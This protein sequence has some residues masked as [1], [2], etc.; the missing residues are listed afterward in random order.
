MNT[1][2]GKLQNEIEAVVSAASVPMLI[3]DYTPIITRYAGLSVKE[4]ANRLVVEDELLDCLSLPIQLG[5]SDEWMKL[6]GFPYEDQVP[7]LVT[8]HFSAAAYP[9][10]RV[11]MIAQF[12][13]PFRGVTS[14]RSEHRAPTLAGDVIVRSHWKAPIWN[15]RPDYS[16]VVIVDLDVTDLR[17][18]ERSLEDA[19]EAKNRLTAVIAHELRNPL[20]AVVGF[21]SILTSDWDTLD[22]DAR[23]EMVTE[24][25]L[26]LGDVTALLDDFLVGS[27]DAIHV[28][29]AEVALTDVFDTV[30]L[31]GVALE[32]DTG[33]S[34]RGDAMR[35]R[36][37]VR[38][39]IRNALRY[40]GPTVRL[41]TESVDGRVR[42]QVRDD[43]SGVPPDIF[44]H[45]FESFTHGENAGSLG[46]G[47][48]VSRALARQMA[49]ELRY[50]RD[51]QWTVFELELAAG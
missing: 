6:Y 31:I 7:D 19:I 36:Q 4:I 49:G 33:L 30:D 43:G 39:L 21:S 11:N 48:S 13:A 2:A 8:R 35:I 9:E 46:L 24:I 37:I 28:E 38:N 20:A 17:E 45:L 34:V 15:D 50:F 41:R 3:V 1:P 18:T 5:A 32:I 16:R 42:I 29:N 27:Q 47:L 12:L 22:D 40:G 25:G 14:I 10:L 51:E 44:D 23:C 26:Q